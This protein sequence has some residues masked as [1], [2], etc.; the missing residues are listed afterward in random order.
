MGGEKCGHQVDTALQAQALANE[1]CFEQGFVTLEVHHIHSSSD[2]LHLL[3]CLL[4]EGLRV[5]V[6][7]GTET[8]GLFAEASLQRVG[9]CGFVAATD[10]IVEGGASK[11]TQQCGL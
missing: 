10:D 8:Q 9:Q 4:A 2:I 11:V 1:R 7:A 3:C 6:I 5:K